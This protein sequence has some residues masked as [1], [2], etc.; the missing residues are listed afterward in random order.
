MNE[1]PYYF[2]IPVYRNSMND[3]LKETTTK[4]N[5]ILTD[6]YAYNRA[7]TSSERILDIFHKVLWHPYQYNE[8]I[9]WICLYI[10][11]NQ[12]RGDYYFI[13]SKKIRQNIKRKRFEYVGKAFE[14]TLKPHLTNEEIYNAILLELEKIKKNKPFLKRHI[15]LNAFNTIA[16][17]IDWQ[18]LVEKLN[19]FVHPRKKITRS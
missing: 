4:K 2:E 11:G 1:E 10:M 15:D 12:V 5:K 3:Y 6:F 18:K 9:G 14:H 19:S 13:S 16:E 8:V 17:F 7:E